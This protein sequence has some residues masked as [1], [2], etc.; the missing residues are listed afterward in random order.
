MK[1]NSAKRLSGSSCLLQCCYEL[2]SAETDARSREESEATAAVETVLTEQSSEAAVTC[3][4]VDGLHDLL[5][6]MMEVLRSCC[7]YCLLM[8]TVATE[9]YVLV[10]TSDGTPSALAFFVALTPRSVLNSVDEDLIDVVLATHHY[11]T[12]RWPSLRRLSYNEHIER[13]VTARL[14]QL[15]EQLDAAVQENVDLAEI[16]HNFFGDSTTASKQTNWSLLAMQMDATWSK[17]KDMSKSTLRKVKDTSED[18]MERVGSGLASTREFVCGDQSATSRAEPQPTAEKIV[19]ERNSTASDERED[20]G[21]KTVTRATEDEVK[22]E[23]VGKRKSNEKHADENGS[24]QVGTSDDKSDADRWSRL[25]T[26][27][28]QTQE[29]VAQISRELNDTWSKVRRASGDVSQR[30]MTSLHGRVDGFAQRVKKGWK[31]TS[32]KIATL[33]RVSDVTPKS[34]KVC[35]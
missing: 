28:N 2:Q 3:R 31:K 32:N 22:E 27:Y 29:V 24:S 25:R 6:P 19:E 7:S 34:G 13:D 9:Y 23:S 14:L 18:L 4:G 15:Q 8:R 11:V 33:L 20:L 17:V 35:P 10:Q 12:S 5:P 1:R 16:F 30:V 21:G 26:V